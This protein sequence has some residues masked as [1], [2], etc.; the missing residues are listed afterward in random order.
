MLSKWSKSWWHSMSI[1]GS[2]TKTFWYVEP[3]K[4]NIE[5]GWMKAWPCAGIHNTGIHFVSAVADF[6]AFRSREAFCT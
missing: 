6:G 4:S 5:V 2:L 3:Q 1:P